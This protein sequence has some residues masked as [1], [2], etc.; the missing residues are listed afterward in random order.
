MLKAHIMHLVHIIAF[1]VGIADDIENTGD[2]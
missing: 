1:V 2:N